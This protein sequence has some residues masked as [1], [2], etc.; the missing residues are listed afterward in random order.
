MVWI[1]WFSVNSLAELYAR[2][3]FAGVFYSI[4]GT[5]DLVFMLF[6][7]SFSYS[8]ANLNTRLGENKL[9]PD[10]E[11]NIAASKIITG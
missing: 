6:L 4:Y 11:C 10:P 2:D 9:S 7:H 8:I 5:N 3:V 1:K